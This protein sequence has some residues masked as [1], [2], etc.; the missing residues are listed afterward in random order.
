VIP[1]G[2]RVK[3]GSVSTRKLSLCEAKTT[4]NLSLFTNDLE[5]LYEKWSS[6]GV[7]LL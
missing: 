6:E 5:R 7:S 1:C 2:G 4:V 3:S